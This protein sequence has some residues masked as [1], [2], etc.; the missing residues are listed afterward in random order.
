MNSGIS[1][2]GTIQWFGSP[3]IS[4]FCCMALVLPLPSPEGISNPAPSYTVTLGIIVV[5]CL[6]AFI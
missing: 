2:L 1:I 3:F 6:M 4:L 5:S